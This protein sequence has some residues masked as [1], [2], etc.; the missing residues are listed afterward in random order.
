MLWDHKVSL[1]FSNTSEMLAVS[2]MKVEVKREDG[3]R[4]CFRN[5]VTT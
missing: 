4:K 3:G 2:N 5:A 1:V